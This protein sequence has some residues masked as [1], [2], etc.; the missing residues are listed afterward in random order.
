MDGGPICVAI[1]GN[2]FWLVVCSRGNVDMWRFRLQRIG[3][4]NQVAAV[5]AQHGD[6][7]HR[8]RFVEGDGTAAVSEGGCRSGRGRS[9]KGV[10]D[11]GS[12]GGARQL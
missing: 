3:G 12:R 8:C 11:G 5:V 6:G 7:F 10:V 1:D 4:R 2:A 9:V